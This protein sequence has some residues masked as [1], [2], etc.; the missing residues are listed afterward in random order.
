MSISLC[1]SVR[2]H[3]ACLASRNFLFVFFKV[4]LARGVCF[5]IGQWF[6]FSKLS[7]WS[8][9]ILIHFPYGSGLW[10]NAFSVELWRGLFGSGSRFF[11]SSLIGS[12]S[13]LLFSRGCFLL[14]PLAGVASLVLLCPF[15]IGWSTIIHNVSGRM[16]A[17]ALLICFSREPFRGNCLSP[18]PSLY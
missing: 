8:R 15:S 14:S 2:E 18:G 16:P 6:L 7:S 1:F 3:P 5:F 9:W 13:P 11:Y 10:S 12:T 4:F 17:N